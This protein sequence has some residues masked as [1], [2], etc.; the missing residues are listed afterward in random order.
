M[1]CRRSLE[2]DSIE[3]AVAEWPPSDKEVAVRLGIG[4]F[5]T[6]FSYRQL[7]LTPSRVVPGWWAPASGCTG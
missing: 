6:V 4:I 7:R 5:N 2:R 3:N 1:R